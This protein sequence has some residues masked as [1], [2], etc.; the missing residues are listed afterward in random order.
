MTT[1][2]K[3]DKFIL[4]ERKSDI[5]LL[6]KEAKYFQS[7]GKCKCCKINFEKSYLTPDFHHKDGDNK[8]NEY[9]NI[10]VL[11]PHC[12]RREDLILLN[13]FDKVFSV[14]AE[15]LTQILS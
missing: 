7:K 13:L 15:E 8:N 6:I 4:K 3:V 12:H 14:P 11:C 10:V 2:D 9:N 1:L 5:P